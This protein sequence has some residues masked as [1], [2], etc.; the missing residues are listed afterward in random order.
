MPGAAVGRRP[1]PQV[2][3]G[4][5]AIGWH[6]A[7]GNPACGPKCDRPEPGV[8]ERSVI[9]RV[10]RST[11]LGRGDEWKGR[12][13]RSPGP[14]APGHES[15]RARGDSGDAAAIRGWS[16]QVAID[17]HLPSLSRG[18]VTVGLGNIDLQPEDA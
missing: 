7:H 14:I 8:P 13:T 12:L 1:D 6:A 9:D 16:G 18:D 11:V 2:R 4:P 3:R 17:K 10:P 5:V 15:R